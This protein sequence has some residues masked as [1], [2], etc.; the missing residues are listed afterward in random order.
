[1]EQQQFRVSFSVG[2]KLLV[3]VV[4]L[5]LVAVGGL[6]V[7]TVVILTEDKRAYT[8]DSQSTEA[9]L[10]GREFVNSA[11]HAL[12]TLRL[13]L[14]TVDPTQAVDPQR[15]ANFQ[16]ILDNQSG[17]VGVW[18]GLIKRE[19]N[20]WVRVAHAF[21]ADASSESKV[22]PGTFE[23]TPEMVKVA[24]PD[25]TSN[26]FAFINVSK[27]GL[28]PTVAV[29]VADAKNISNPTGIP[30]AVGFVLTAGLGSGGRASRITLANR[31]GWVLF[32]SD[33]A[34][35]FDK[36]SVADDPLFATAVGGQVSAGAQEYHFEG[37]RYLGS[38][39]RPGFGLVVLSRIAW[40]KAMKATFTLAEKFILIG[41]MTIG[42][43]II[44]AIL[45]SK[46][47]T[48][49][50]KRLYQA[51]RAVASGDFNVKLEARGRDEIGA[52]TGSFVTMSQKIIELIEASVRKAH[53]ENELAIASTVQKTLIPPPRFQN[54]MV[55]IRSHY[56][57][58]S[59]CGGDWWGF[60][61]VGRKLVLMIAD[62][63]GHGLPSALIT[64]AARSCF[65][66]MYKLAQEDADFSF[67]PGTM[68]AYANRVV[69][70]AALGKIMMTFYLGVIDLETG[71]LTYASAGHNPPWLFKAGDGGQ[72]QLKSLTAVGQRL[73]EARDVQ[74]YEEKVVQVAPGDVLFL[75]TDGLMEGKD[76][77]GEMYGKKRT[78]H[79]VESAVPGG[80][81][82]VIDDIV[83]AFNKH[84]VGKELDDDITL[85]ACKILALA[86]AAPV[87]T[88]VPSPS[89]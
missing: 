36:K 27:V 67:S 71:Q 38:Y 52:L 46:S 49:P 3:G 41:C 50:L 30:V 60:F 7:L 69:H 34:R 84:N 82:Q 6:N 54:K 28:P 53:L 39:I 20:A 77:A 18:L 55:H 59:E 22:G 75:Y 13:S 64:A 14:A 16:A 33:L 44:F 65:S 47:M 57:S 88:Q 5:L 23:I 61:G 43:A 70:D 42:A 12:D 26:S 11:R 45:F 80:P 31:E 1:M 10:V 19:S 2:T 62:A 86:P 83:A 15:Q 48:A 37:T 58:A 89:A 35:F 79:V 66:V 29:L 78:R 40:R 72:Y 4:S 32:D 8:Y 87:P 25:I 51:T 81:E 85:A 74:P 73:G 68:L 56:Q 21:R 17:V 9:T 76:T 24:M 63:T